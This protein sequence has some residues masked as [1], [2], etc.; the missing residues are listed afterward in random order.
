MDTFDISMTPEQTVVVP[1]QY[2]FPP[3]RVAL[4]S[5]TLKAGDKVCA[6]FYVTDKDGVI[7]F[8]YSAG[9]NIPESN[10]GEE[11]LA[12]GRIDFNTSPLV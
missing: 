6:R 2:D 8:D 1:P 12:V 11:F 9:V 3:T 10:I 4:P 5:G 7:K